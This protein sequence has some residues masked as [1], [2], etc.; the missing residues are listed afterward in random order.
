MDES[1]ENEDKQAESAEAKKKEAQDAAWKAGNETGEKLA[2]DGVNDG[3][4]IA[5]AGKSAGRRAAEG[6]G[7]EAQAGE[8]AGQHG[9]IEGWSHETMTQV[10][11]SVGA[12]E[13]HLARRQ[14]ER[15]G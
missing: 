15:E 3:A 2:R 7:A 12:T 9:A 10:D 13:E 11:Q 14:L 6:V 5:E 1:Q 8:E 4:T